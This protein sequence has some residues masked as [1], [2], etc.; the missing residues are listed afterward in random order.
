MGKTFEATVM[1]QHL[2]G[3]KFKVVGVTADDPAVHVTDPVRVSENPT[4]YRL[5]IRVGP[6]S[7]PRQVNARVSVHT[8]TKHSPQVPI[9][10]YGE[11]VSAA[12]TGG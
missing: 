2:E 6:E 4:Q 11:I 3:G 10:V 12:S 7:K 9:A 8:D 5:T 1:L